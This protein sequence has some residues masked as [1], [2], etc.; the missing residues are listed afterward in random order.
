MS[1]FA[2][3]FGTRSFLFYGRKSAP[4]QAMHY[5]MPGGGYYLDFTS[6]HNWL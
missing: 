6:R 5:G 3:W 2:T 1:V 4:P